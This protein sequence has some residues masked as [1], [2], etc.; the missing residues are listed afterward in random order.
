M[1]DTQFAARLRAA[2]EE[3]GLTQA[4][5]GARIGVSGSMIAQY[6]SSAPYARKP[7]W[8]TLEKLANAM[9]IPRFAE[10]LSIP[11]SRLLGLPYGEGVRLVR[12]PCNIYTG[13]SNEP[14]LK[15]EII[16][17]HRCPICRSKVNGFRDNFCWNCGVKFIRKERDT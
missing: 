5:L 13:D 1:N 15:G 6:E 14:A 16:S 2:R 7:K 11:V 8:G 9:E 10:A 3:A 4:E 17:A 12:Y